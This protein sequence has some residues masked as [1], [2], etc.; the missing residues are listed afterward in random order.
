MHEIRV[1]LDEGQYLL[2]VG[3]VYCREV[4]DARYTHAMPAGFYAASLDC[5][6]CGKQLVELDALAS[7][8]VM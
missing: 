6:G 4:V 3:C 5:M 8:R 2:N 7:G 1:E